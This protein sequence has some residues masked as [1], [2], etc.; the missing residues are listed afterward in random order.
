M[1]FYY[2]IYKNYNCFT[3]SEKEREGEY[4]WGKFKVNYV[5]RTNESGIISITFERLPNPTVEHITFSSRLSGEFHH[6]NGYGK[7]FKLG[8]EIEDKTKNKEVVIVKGGD[9]TNSWCSRSIAVGIMDFLNDFY[10]FDSIKDYNLSR[11]IKDNSLW[12]NKDSLEKFILLADTINL[13]LKYHSLNPA[14]YC[15]REFEKD[16]KKSLKKLIENIAN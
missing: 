6:E 9:W 14:S 13:Y 8:W 5:N 4:Y 10:Q 3:L 16:I 1:L 7:V 12:S 11:Q 2:Y 15:V